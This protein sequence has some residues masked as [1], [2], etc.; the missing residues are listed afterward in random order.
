MH[1]AARPCGPVAMVV[2]NQSRR[3]WIEWLACQLVGAVGS[4]KCSFPNPCILPYIT[5]ASHVLVSSVTLDSGCSRSGGPRSCSM[6]L[7][8]PFENKLISPGRYHPGDIGTLTATGAIVGKG[9]LVGRAGGAG[10]SSCSPFCKL[11][12]NAHHTCVERET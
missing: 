11:V 5:G 8:G 6:I 12:G 4:V 2:H 7:Y 3:P 9:A 10:L 1:A